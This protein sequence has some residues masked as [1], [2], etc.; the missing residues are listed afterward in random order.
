M[1]MAAAGAEIKKG[2]GSRRRFFLDGNILRIHKP[3]P[4]KEIKCYA[5]EEIRGFLKSLD[6][7]P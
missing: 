4:Q 6:I 1:F 3:H 7:K 2:S 5:V